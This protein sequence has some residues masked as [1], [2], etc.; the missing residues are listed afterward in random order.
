MVHRDE[1][2]ANRRMSAAKEKEKNGRYAYHSK[3]EI[4]K[5]K[6]SRGKNVSP[7]E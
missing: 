1:L 6:S 4:K 3:Q 5:K 7:K 2:A